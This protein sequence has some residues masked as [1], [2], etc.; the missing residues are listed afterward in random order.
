MNHS[1]LLLHTGLD[2]TWAN[3]VPHNT[4]VLPLS[5]A[6]VQAARQPNQTTSDD[7]HNVINDHCYQ[8]A[9]TATTMPPLL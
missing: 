3:N 1:Y 6:T 4:P 9:T 7:V 5:M 2:V 8:Y